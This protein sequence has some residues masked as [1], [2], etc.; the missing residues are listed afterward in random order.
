M[1]ALEASVPEAK[2]IS[3]KEIPETATV[4][5]EEELLSLEQR[6][7]YAEV[8]DKK[9][10]E[11]CDALVSD[12]GF[13]Q[14]SGEGKTEAL[15]KAKEYAAD[16]A[17]AAVS[18]FSDVQKGFGRDVAVRI[19]NDVALK[20]IT[21]IFGDID[22]NTKKGS[23]NADNIKALDAAYDQ[24][25]ELPDMQRDKVLGDAES[26]AA[27]YFDARGSGVGTWDFIQARDAVN[28]APGS[29]SVDKDTGKP[30]QTNA[31]KYGAIAGLERMTDET[32]DSLM[33]AWMPDYDPDNGKTD[34]AELKY[35]YARKELR[36]SPSQ[37]AEAYRVNSQY[38]LKGDKK[39]AW[40]AMGLSDS[41]AEMLYKLLGGHD[42]QFNQKL[43][44]LYG[45]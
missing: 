15:K 9:V 26:D 41:T 2:G 11:Y 28:S 18:D 31:D 22:T 7:Q 23:S 42:E 14:L 19:V 5:G 39:D 38:S 20:S 24:V 35:D 3:E 29:G 4:A 25:S 6:Q 37:Y 1:D 40:K 8:Y 30:K 44:E 13:Q 36:L 21:D 27:I 45:G 32:I 43:V 33:K 17:K 34:R 12:P 10:N 16:H